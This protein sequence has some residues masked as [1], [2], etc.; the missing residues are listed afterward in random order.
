MQGLG[1]CPGLGAH[2]PPLSTNARCTQLPPPQG[3]FRREGTPEAAPEAVRQ[4]VRQ[5]VRRSPKRLGA[6]TVGYKMPLSLA[7]GQWLD[8]GGGGGVRPPPS[9]ASLPPPPALQTLW[10]CLG[11]EPEYVAAV[12]E[13]RRLFCGCS[14]NPCTPPASGASPASLPPVSHTSTTRGCGWC[15][16]GRRCEG[17]GMQGDGGVEAL[18]RGPAGVSGSGTGV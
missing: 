14:C 18:P 7:L 9:H 16:E 17:R 10:A 8:P 6:V 13:G 5:A 12:V 2:S 11:G 4:A 1:T 15:H 3:C